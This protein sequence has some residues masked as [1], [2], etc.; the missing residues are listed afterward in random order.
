M[1][2]EKLKQAKVK[3]NK[4]KIKKLTK[5]ENFPSWARKMILRKNQWK[6][7]QRA[8]YPYPSTGW[9]HDNVNVKSKHNK[10]KKHVTSKNKKEHE[11]LSLS[12]TRLLLKIENWA[13]KTTTT[14]TNTTTADTTT[15]TSSS[16]TTNGTTI[17]T[18]TTTGTTSTN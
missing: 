2:Q 15:T 16:T 8:G 3:W 1:L 18:T 10:K 13:E 14:T 17:N 12:G 4:I 11:T 5:Q 9:I 6:Q 7:K